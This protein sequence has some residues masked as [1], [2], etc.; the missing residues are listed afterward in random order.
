MKI[1]RNVILK[2]CTSIKI[3]G[4]AAYF[5]I[6]KDTA[7]LKSA[8]EFAREKKIPFTII[9]MGT[10]LL[11]FDRG[12]NG[13]VIKVAGGMS[14]IKIERN[15]ITVGAGLYLPKLLNLV[16]RKSLGG[17]EFLAGIPGTVGGAVVMNAGAWGSEIA[18]YVI[19]VRAMDYA[20]KEKIINHKKMGFGYRKSIFQNANLILSEVELKLGKRRKKEIKQL[21]ASY[22]EKRKSSQPLG[23]PNAGSVFKNPKGKYA[24]QLIEAAGAKGMRIGDAQVST[25]HANFIVNLGEASARDVIKLMTRVQKVVKEKHKIQLEP[26]LKVMVKFQR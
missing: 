4:A 6:P 25:K 3:G 10:N 14:Q 9:G 7:D 22:L 15:R 2:N 24:G 8:L 20:G 5:C 23:I 21:I 19:R 1:L 13:L 16:M 26:E 11:A 12:F 17:L 18:K